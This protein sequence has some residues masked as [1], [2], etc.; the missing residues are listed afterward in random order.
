VV[1]FEDVQQL[2]APDD[3]QVAV[4]QRA[5]VRRRL[6]HRRLLA[7]LVAEHVAFACFIGWAKKL[8]TKL[9]AIILL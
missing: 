6:A 5:D 9:M 2:V 4:G 8:H 3:V 7:E 1:E